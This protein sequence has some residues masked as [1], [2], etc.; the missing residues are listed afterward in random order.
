MTRPR[1]FSRWFKKLS[2]P[3]SPIRRDSMLGMEVL[4]S[5]DVPANFN[6]TSILDDGSVGTLRWAINQADADVTSPTTV[7]ILPTASGQLDLTAA[8][9]TITR[10]MTITDDSG[11]VFSISGGGAYQI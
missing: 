2:Q 11:G 5:R 6:V 1:L 7:T 3:T 10:A 8:L 4:E 9:P